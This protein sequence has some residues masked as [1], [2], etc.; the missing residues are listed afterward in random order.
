VLKSS[1]SRHRVATVAALLGMCS[2]PPCLWAQGNAKPTIPTRPFSE[3][4]S[5]IAPETAGAANAPQLYQAQFPVRNVTPS[6][7]AYW[8]DP[9]SQQMPLTLKASLALGTDSEVFNKLP[10]LPGNA[11]GPAGLR[12]PLGVKRVIAVDPQDL[13]LAVGTKEGLQAL[14]ALLPTLD[15]PLVQYEVEAQFLQMSR[16]DFFKIGLDFGQFAEQNP[17]SIGSVLG[18]GT[19]RQNSPNTMGRFIKEGRIKLISAPRVTTMDGLTAQ[20]VQTTSIPIVVNQEAFKQA[21]SQKPVNATQGATPEM[22]RAMGYV[23][24]SIGMRVT[25]YQNANDLI[26]LSIT[27]I[28]QT[29]TVSVN[30]TIREAESFAIQMSPAKDEQQVVVFVTVRRIQRN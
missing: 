7:V 14:D 30:A 8:L 19:K 10:R 2:F 1:S 26:S 16:A 23:S 12:M 13:L 17:N 28:L 29:R 27:P 5:P 4:I 9:A 11:N 25:P 18:P 3:R 22:L 15:V 20:A 21:A 24:T 6:L